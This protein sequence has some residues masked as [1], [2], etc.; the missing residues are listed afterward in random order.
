MTLER[1]L[2]KHGSVPFQRMRSVQ[3]RVGRLLAAGSESLGCNI[4]FWQCLCHVSVSYAQ[5]HADLFRFSASVEKNTSLFWAKNQL[6][7]SEIFLR[8]LLSAV[9]STNNSMKQLNVFFSGNHSPKS[10]FLSTNIFRLFFFF[11]KLLKT[12][13]S[14]TVFN[15]FSE[16]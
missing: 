3:Q 6:N 7:W 9:Y 1:V 13:I 4:V 16:I 14:M 5:Q 2:K 8:K 12:S 10:S 11:F 15:L